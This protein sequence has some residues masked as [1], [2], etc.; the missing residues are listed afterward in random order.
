MVELRAEFAMAARKAGRT[1]SQ[2]IEEILELTVSRSYADKP[3]VQLGLH[4]LAKSSIERQRFAANRPNE[5]PNCAKRPV[6]WH[7]SL[8]TL[9]Q[10]GYT[11]E[12]ST[13]FKTGPSHP[14]SCYGGNVTFQVGDKVIYP[15]HGLGIVERIEEKTILGTT[16]GFFHCAS[17]PT[18]RRAGSGCER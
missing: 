8:P 9:G 4:G 3:L 11:R 17:C 12:R 6:F 10:V 1:Y 14:S 7:F 2:L 13:R 15:N 18:T 16:C 5:S